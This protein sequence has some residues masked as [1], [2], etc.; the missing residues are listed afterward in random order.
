MWAKLKLKLSACWAANSTWI[1][2]YDFKYFFSLLL[3]W[4][5][6]VDDVDLRRAKKKANSNFSQ[7]ESLELPEYWD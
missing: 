6:T 7:L 3:S 2:S 5:T 4:V 1:L